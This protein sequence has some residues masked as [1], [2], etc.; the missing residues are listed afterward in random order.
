MRSAGNTGAVAA[1]RHRLHK[2]SLKR[3]RSSIKTSAP[4]GTSSHQQPAAGAPHEKPTPH[5]AQLFKVGALPGNVSSAS[6]PLILTWLG[7]N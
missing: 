4:T 5:A 1:V 2:Q 7:L 6:P 3:A